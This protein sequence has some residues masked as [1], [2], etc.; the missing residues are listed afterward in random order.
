MILL[1]LTVTSGALKGREKRKGQTNLYHLS[2]KTV[3]NKF[4][5]K[6]HHKSNT[7]IFSI[8]GDTVIKMN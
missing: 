7:N 3:V 6:P 8:I 4:N 1:K 2:V 5:K